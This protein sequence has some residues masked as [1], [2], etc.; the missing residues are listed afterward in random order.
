[1][2]EAAPIADLRDRAG[3]DA[4]AHEGAVRRMFD[5]IAPTYDLLNTLL[6][7]GVD[8]RWRA[9]AVAA[10]A[11]APRG[12]VLDLCAGTMD[13]TA[14]V[15]Q[16]RPGDRVI[17]LDFAAAM[18][19]AGR[20]KA[21]SAEIVVGDALDLPFDDGQIAACICGFGM[22]NLSDPLRGALGV[23]R[24]L[25]P[26]GVFVTLD[27]FRPTRAPTRL[28]HAAYANVVLPVL[29]GIVSG[30]RSAYRYLA[31]SMAGFL[32][33]DEYVRALESLGF[34]RV[35]ATDATLGVASIVRAEVAS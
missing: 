18:L 2:S 19:E 24:V 10:L 35:R 34:T 33:R 9:R 12:A 32:S 14:M 15:A 28:F 3:D 26:G 1:V 6:S 27:F 29:G 23:R 4:R 21:P 30:D 25:Q 31:R 7:A 13:L 17:A 20:S 16:A 5:R 11:G 8:K 22:R